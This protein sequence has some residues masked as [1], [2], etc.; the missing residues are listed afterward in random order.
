MDK[1]MKMRQEVR[2]R[3]WMEKIRECRSS[4]KTV[5]A[6]CEENG[7]TRKT[8]YYH[9]RIIRERLCEGY[10]ATGTLPGRREQQMP[11]PLIQISPAKEQT[12][13]MTVHGKGIE[14]EVGSEISKELLLCVLEALQC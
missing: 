12:P 1:V 10:A 6:W 3:E 2:E 14:I 11:V 8:Y 5:T 13:V 7:I 4:G 9:L